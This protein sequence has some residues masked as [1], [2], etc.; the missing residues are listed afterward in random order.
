M[1]LFGVFFPFPVSA[2]ISGESGRFTSVLAAESVS[3]S[4][5]LGI[6]VFLVQLLTGLGSGV[7]S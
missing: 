6:G 3:S 5:R 2:S 7:L 1:N 4:R